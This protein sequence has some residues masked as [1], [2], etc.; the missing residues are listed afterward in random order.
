[1]AL[2]LRSMPGMS[3]IYIQHSHN[4]AFYYGGDRWVLGRNTAR[5]FRRTHEAIAFCLENNLSYAQVRVCFG[6]GAAD[7][8]VPVTRDMAVAPASVPDGV[9]W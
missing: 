5:C 4:P 1:M 2:R 8:V 6:P 7:T 9:V 3:A